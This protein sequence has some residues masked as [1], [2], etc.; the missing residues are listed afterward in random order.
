MRTVRVPV[1][2]DGYNSALERC[3]RALKPRDRLCILHLHRA[4]S[5]GISYR[6]HLRVT[7]QCAVLSS[8]STH[9]A[10]FESEKRVDQIVGGLVQE[11]HVWLGQEGARNGHTPALASRKVLH[12]GLACGSYSLI[13]NNVISKVAARPNELIILLYHAA[14]RHVGK[15]PSAVTWCFA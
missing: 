8:C 6:R 10:A 4:K 2:R 15:L 12:L 14:P 13:W 1:V 3:E 9:V 7:T 11:Q 5:S